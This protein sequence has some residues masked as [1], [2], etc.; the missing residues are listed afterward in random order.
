[1]SSTTSNPLHNKT[2]FSLYIQHTQSV[3]ADY[4]TNGG[5][6]AYTGKPEEKSTV[7]KKLFATSTG[8]KS[9]RYGNLF[10]K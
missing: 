3:F 4:I 9:S 10:N 5:Q 1:M 7:S 2:V 8:K 6:F